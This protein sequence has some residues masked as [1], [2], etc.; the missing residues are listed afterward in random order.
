MAGFDFEG[1]KVYSKTFAAEVYLHL[2][3]GDRHTQLGNTNHWIREHNKTTLSARPVKEVKE[4]ELHVFHAAVIAAT[5]Y[6][7]KGK[8][9]GIN[10]ILYSPVDGG[11]WKVRSCGI[12]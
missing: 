5:G 7:Q 9:I 8:Q 11:S 4:R 6:T 2:W 12:K 3:P 1:E 10:S